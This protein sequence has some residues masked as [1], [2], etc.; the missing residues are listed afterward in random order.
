MSGMIRCRAIG[1]GDIEIRM[2]I[3]CREEGTGMPAGTRQRASGSL[4]RRAA[5]AVVEALLLCLHHTAS[6]EV[7]EKLQAKFAQH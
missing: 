5:V 4:A 2:S 1:T 6:F 7:G 3:R